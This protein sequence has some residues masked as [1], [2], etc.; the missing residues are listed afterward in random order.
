MYSKTNEVSARI[1]SLRSK[2]GLM[3]SITKTSVLFTIIGLMALVLSGC[4]TTQSA[5]AHSP[6]NLSV[7]GTQFTSASH[8]ELVLK[9]DRRFE[10]DYPPSPY[11]KMITMVYIPLYP[12]AIQLPIPYENDGIMIPMVNH[13]ESA[14]IDFITLGSASAVQAWYSKTFMKAG[15]VLDIKGWV[16]H[17]N[18][19][20]ETFHPKGNRNVFVTITSMPL[21]YSSGI[22]IF[23]M[24]VM[25]GAMR[26]SL[27]GERN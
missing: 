15:W 22:F 2:G 26:M 12:H 21:F 25:P 24:R 13:L 14:H 7:Y 1:F 18:S 23:V 20:V 19:L 10:N 27:G 16:S 11:P 3:K 17:T 8:I 5:H 9:R 4:G 6:S